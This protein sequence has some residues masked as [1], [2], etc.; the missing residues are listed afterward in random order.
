MSTVSLTSGGHTRFIQSW[1]RLTCS[2]M[3]IPYYVRVFDM[4][5]AVGQFVY[6]AVKEGLRESLTGCLFGSE[7]FSLAATEERLEDVDNTVFTL[8][9]FRG[10]STHVFEEPE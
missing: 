9:L 10:H 6:S 1:M 5:D 4:R 7:I 8:T 3:R 2:M